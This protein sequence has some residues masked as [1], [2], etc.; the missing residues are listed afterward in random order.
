MGNKSISYIVG[1]ILWLVLGGTSNAANS[2]SSYS[3]DMKLIQSRIVNELTEPKVDSSEIVTILN[4][5]NIDGSWSGIDYKD[6]SLTGFRHSKHLNYL[7][8][9]SRAYTKR[10][11]AFYY[12]KR[13]KKAIDLSLNFWLKNDFRAE[14]LWYE[15]IGTPTILTAV[16]YLL[17]DSLTKEQKERTMMITA[18]A[19]MNASYARPSGDRIKIASIVA[20]NALLKNNADL[21]KQSLDIIENEVKFSTGRGMQYDYSFHHRVD[22]VN[23]T[24]TYGL[25]Y[26]GVFADWALYVANTSYQFS[27]HSVNQFVNYYLD[28]I[29]KM[30]IYAKYPDPGAMNREI[31]R[32]VSE[33]HW[34]TKIL[35]C[36]KNITDYRKAEIQKIIDVRLNRTQPDFSHSVFFWCSEYYSHQR[37]D[38]YTSVRLFSSR[39][40]NME[41]PYNGEGIWNHHRGDGSNY[42]SVTGSEYK[43]ISPV[44]DWQKIPGTTSVQ[45]DSLSGVD[46]VQKMGTMDFVGAVTDGKY[47]TVAFD[48]ISPHDSIR[49]RK[50]W[51]FFDKE[52]VCLGAGINAKTDAETV[53]TINQCLLKGSVI[54]QGILRRDT[55]TKG[56]HILD[57]AKWL[58]HDKIGYIF[59]EPMKMSLIN[60][61]A[62]GSWYSVNKQT[63]SPKEKIDMEVFKLWINHGNNTND[64]K[65]QYIVM[66]AS[67]IEEVD[68]AQKSPKVIILKNTSSIQAVNH[69]VLNIV[70][71]VFYSADTLRLE[72]EITLGMDT[73]RCYYTPTC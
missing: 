30:M 5:L 48:F 4:T 58:F 52:Y 35:D 9:L 72:N 68:D 66:P 32:A 41:I 10:G 60:N 39:N 6:V 40:A 22:N 53:T 12:N 27:S 65:Y 36:L 70:Q 64:G 13:L 26:A 59:T 71:A 57:S 19:N 11:S 2:N 69:K 28:G 24:L 17:D 38:Y 33:E 14:N 20:K 29:C 25:G 44:Y 67:T 43:G 61:N 46:E 18:R 62:S 23:N 49:A 56:E 45:R 8:Q 15:Q 3:S 42:I 51:F 54:S 73:P 37:P 7:L 34:D 16:L 55:L 63:S 50:S 47:G 1:L 21:F 31:T